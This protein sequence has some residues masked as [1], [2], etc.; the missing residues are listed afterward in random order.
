MDAQAQIVIG[1]KHS[2]S[3]QISN[4]VAVKNGLNDI[5]VKFQFETDD[6]DNTVKTVVFAKGK[7]S[8]YTT[9]EDLDGN[10]EMVVLDEATHTCNIPESIL[11]DAQFTNA[12]F[13]IGVYGQ[14]DD[15][16]IVSTWQFYKLLN[17][18]YIFSAIPDP[19]QPIYDQLLA[20]MAQTRQIAQSVRDDADAGLFNGVGIS[21]IVFKGM[22]PNRDYVYSI[23]LTDG[24]SYDI[25]IPH[26]KDADEGNVVLY[27]PQ[28]LTA[29][30]QAQ[31]RNNIGVKQ[32]DWDE[33]DTS[34]MAFIQNKPTQVSVFEND[35]EYI[36]ID[37]VKEE[38]KATRK[39]HNQT[40][41][42]AEW[43]VTHNLGCY[44][45]VT[46]VDSAGDACFGEIHYVSE[47]Q[48]KIKF[49][50]AFQGTAYLIS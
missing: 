1:L 17:G 39:I 37:D 27:A 13:S 28:T 25:T 46:I 24:S 23:V 9:I 33:D 38:I 48:L 47:N 7:I 26:G 40:V 29:A 35:A 21:E 15:F 44:P 43:V 11:Y 19:P 20:M 22:L 32:A 4:K 5:A 49:S 50:A 6:W 3:R 45:S 30:E 34:S 12:G 2:Q 18:S 36:I 31:A 42:A 41:A 8:Q 14:A 16:R 10:L